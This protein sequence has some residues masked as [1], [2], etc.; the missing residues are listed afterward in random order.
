MTRTIVI[1][2]D[3][4]KGTLSAIEVAASI[5]D[6]WSEVCP[7]DRLLLLPLADGG[8]GT[9]DAIAAASSGSRRMTVRD[10]H[11]P[12]GH[13][14]TSEWLLLADGSAVVELAQSSGLPLMSRLDPLHATTRGLGEVVCAAVRHGITSL[15]I[16]LGGSATTDGGAGALRA[17]GVEIYDA[18]GSPLPEGG[19]GL[20]HLA[21]VDM[22]RLLPRPPGGVTLLTDVT[23]PLLGPL[24]A[25]HVFGPQKGA[26]SADVAILE[27]ALTCW[28]AT[29][30][31]DP[32]RAGCGAG[33]GTGFGFV[34]AWGAE[35]AP[36]A[37]FIAELTGLASAAV[38]A[39]VV[40]TGEGRFDSQSAGGKVV[41]Q[42]IRRCESLGTKLGIVAGD[43][44]ASTPHWSVSLAELSG[45]TES[46]M[47]ES[48]KWL[49]AAGA[50]A[51][52]QFSD[53]LGPSSAPDSTNPCKPGAR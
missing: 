43:V 53:T 9:L 38:S 29:V 28:A 37:D 25:S 40:L 42:L 23:A 49:R 7:G 22:S 16:G 44:K 17:L 30:G 50:R 8:E 10:V 26:S 14:R 19:A 35:I 32:S 46:A 52:R 36:G 15:T 51:A 13:T 4:F 47:E 31:G 45:S 27:T 41:G 3:S 24:G 11:G 34:S 39:D 18:A 20:F 48:R 6:G 5:A 1:A 12:D 2:P 33:G 21:S